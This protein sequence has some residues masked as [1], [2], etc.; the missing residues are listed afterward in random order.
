MFFIVSTN[1]ASSFCSRLQA[2][3]SE[4]TKPVFYVKHYDGAEIEEINGMHLSVFHQ[5]PNLGILI[6]NIF[7]LK[8]HFCRPLV[9]C[10]S[11]IAVHWW[12]KVIL[13]KFFFF[14]E[15]VSFEKWNEI[16]PL[17]MWWTGQ[18]NLQIEV[19]S[20]ILSHFWVTINLQSKYQL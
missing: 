4:F 16:N 20:K 5:F 10:W 11:W 18:R 13:C 2:E 14:L 9:L 12:K 8:G 19:Y 6:L 7:S 1:C 17:T 15:A 3:E